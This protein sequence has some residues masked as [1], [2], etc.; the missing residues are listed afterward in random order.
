MLLVLAIV[1]VLLAIGGQVALLISMFSEV[2]PRKVK[3]E[4]AQVA[5]ADT[6]APAEPVAANAPAVHEPTTTAVA[7]ASTVAEPAVWNRM[8]R[9]V[10]VD[11]S[12]SGGTMSVTVQ[13]KAQVGERELNTAAVAICV[14]FAALGGTGSSVVWR[15][16]I[17]L[18]IPQWEN[19]ST[20]SFTVHFPG[21]SREFVGFVV[22]TYFR[23]Q[24]QDVAAAPPSL[25]PLAPLP[26]VGGAS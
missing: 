25:R 22:R 1:I 20:K 14:Q 26:T 16:P 21:A 8:I 13:A 4:A 5:H 6:G 17:W 12:E 19:F 2:R 23:R 15:E 9:I 11:R 24:M 18:P 7:P 3:L 10:R